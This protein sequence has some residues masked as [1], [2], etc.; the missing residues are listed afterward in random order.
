MMKKLVLSLFAFFLAA[1]IMIAQEA[2]EQTKSVEK[3]KTEE[4]ATQDGPI[5]TLESETV[6]YG[7]I[8]RNAEPFRSVNFTNTGNEPLIIKSARGNCG[9]TVP[10]WPREAVMPGETKELKIRYA[11]NRLG[12]INKRVTI[13][14]NEKTNNRHVIK[15]VGMINKPE[16]AKG[17]PE[18]KKNILNSDKK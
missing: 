15:V 17:V 9:C 16:E 18:G 5:M 3:V 13:L 11:T 7:T 1:N 2:K 6:D 10:T 4:K 14:T 8:E 12:K